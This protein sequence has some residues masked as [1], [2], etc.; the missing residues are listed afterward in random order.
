MSKQ[1]FYVFLAHGKTQSLL[2]ASWSES[3]CALTKHSYYLGIWQPS[4]VFN[5]NVEINFS[6]LE[7]IP[8]II[9]V[10]KG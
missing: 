6:Q 10:V 2:I 1:S 7:K 9:I 4:L 8:F 5:G 3:L